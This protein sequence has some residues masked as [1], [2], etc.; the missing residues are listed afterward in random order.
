MRELDPHQREILAQRRIASVATV[1]PD[2]T[3]HLT[4]TWFVF[5]GDAFLLAIP[6]SSVK[7]RNLRSN[8]RLAVMIDVRQAGHELGISV[9][10]TAE[11]LEGDAARDVVARVHAKYLTGEALAD[12]GVGPAFAAFDDLAIRLEPQRWITWDMSE[13]D[14]QA[15][16]GKLAARSYLRS[17][18]A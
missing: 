18:R 6:S 15:F 1:G 3:P 5:D 12:P 10:G 9:S 14:R 4:A 17:I 13:L 2:G 7:A 11:I 16:G 8:P